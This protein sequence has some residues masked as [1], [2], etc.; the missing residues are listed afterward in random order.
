MTGMAAELHEHDEQGGATGHR[1]DDGD[2]ATACRNGGELHVGGVYH[3]KHC[4][5][6]RTHRGR[7]GM[8]V[9]EI[10]DE[11]SQQ[12][13]HQQS[14]RMAAPYLPTVPAGRLGLVRQDG[15]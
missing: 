13:N 14:E 2:P 4:D 7:E 5:E 12:R 8:Q 11:Q 9:E 6:T 10:G 3:S 15:G 1:A